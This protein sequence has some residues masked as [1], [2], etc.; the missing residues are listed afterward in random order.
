MKRWKNQLLHVIMF[1]FAMTMFVMA[2]L[3]TVKVRDTGDKIVLNKGWTV[4]INN[5]IFEDVDLSSFKFPVTNKGDFIVVAANMPKSIPDNVTMRVHMIHSVT[6]VYLDNDLLY[7]FGK[8]D[9]REGKLIGYGTRFVSIPDE[10]RGKTLKITMFVTE[11]N[12]FTTITPPEIYNESDCFVVFFWERIIPLVVSITLVVIGL[13]ISLVTFALYFKSYSMEKLFCIGIFSLCIGCWTICSYNLDYLF[14]GNLVV[15]T[16]LEFFSLYLIPF[17]LL[18]YFRKD[19][20]ERKEKIESFVFY[21]LVFIEIQLFLLSAICQFENIAHLTEFNRLYL[22]FMG[23]GAA[24]IFFL[25]FQD[26]RKDR[27]H[28][29]LLVGFVLM[30]IIGCRD[31]IVFS[32]CKSGYGNYNESEYKSYISV[33]ALLFVVAMLVEFIH[34]VRVK[35]YKSAETQLLEKIAYEDVL[36]NLS[37]RR[38]CEEIFEE[39]DKDTRSFAIVQFDLNNLKNTN[40]DF[41]H[42]A[43]DELL[44]RFSEAIKKAFGDVADLGR[45]GGDEFIAIIRDSDNV[46]VFERVK[47]LKEIIASENI[48]KE[49]KLSA[50]IGICLSKE[51]ENAGAHAVYKEADKRMYAD[52]EAYYKKSGRGRR[53]NDT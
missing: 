8:E 43:G 25:L 19:V 1:I 39:I 46:D 50:S 26:M 2:Y 23:V 49:I 51:L 33:G 6:E 41:G 36:T 16:Y 18:M 20:E 34:E 47:V 48:E 53:R 4:R 45:M 17:P 21:A 9:Y 30:L 40:D 15:K 5:E 37:T 38:R 3:T 44:I 12:A 31:I 29:A 28:K 35:V 13:C 24:F 32:I 22:I 10:S 14:T 52:K 27:S 42:E 11:N 7:E